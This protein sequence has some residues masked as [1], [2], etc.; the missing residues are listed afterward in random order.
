MG[1]VHFPL[2]NTRKDVIN[3]W[4]MFHYTEE[5][6]EEFIIP[7]QPNENGYYTIFLKERPDNGSIPNITSKPVI[8]GYVEY[9]YGKPVDKDKK[10]LLK[11]NQY[12][13]NYE[14]G[15]IMFHP[16][17]AGNSV[18][19]DYWGRGSVIEAEDI[20][21]LYSEIT[22]AQESVTGFFNYFKVNGYEK[23]QIPI[24]EYF[25]N[26]SSLEFTWEIQLID[27][28]KENSI[29]IKDITNNIILDF[30]I[31]N[32]GI[33]IIPYEK[34]SYNE[35][36]KIIFEISA[37]TTYGNKFSKQ[38]TVEWIPVIYYGSSDIPINTNSDID[39]STLKRSMYTE[40]SGEFEI[41]KNYPLILTPTSSPELKSIIDGSTNLNI[42]ITNNNLITNISSTSGISQTYSVYA[43]KYKMPINS[44]IYIEVGE[45]Q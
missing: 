16:D 31:E 25:S 21:A 28:L 24:Q 6:A 43:S 4:H 23:T 9:L 26:I 5:T 44:K 35:Y 40:F 34:I 18:I 39:L 14:T 11:S 37:Y 13:I 7:Q 12:F 17:A 45:W 8:N 29:T 33:K 15:E 38:A 22:K 42:A 41:E 30:N 20:N 3:N 2:V 19:V 36:K 32:T 10:L 27:N 1:K